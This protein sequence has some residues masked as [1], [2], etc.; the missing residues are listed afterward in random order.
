MLVVGLRLGATSG[1]EPSQF[2]ELQELR[3]AVG[4]ITTKEQDV[5]RHA[6]LIGALP[7]HT[8]RPLRRGDPRK[9]AADRY[10]SFGFALDLADSERHI[11]VATHFRNIHSDNAF[12]SHLLKN[13]GLEEI[14]TDALH[15]GDVVIYFHNADPA[16]AG[17]VFGDRVISK[18]GLGNLWE[19]A[20]FEIPVSYGTDVR[21]FRALGAGPA[22]AAFLKYAQSRGVQLHR[23][24]GFTTVSSAKSVNSVKA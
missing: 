19:H 3:K 6:A 1:Q 18:W 2:M 7:D 24:P 14:Q 16:H 12:V 5:S 13:G 22:E 11:A 4:D 10:N 20:L 8:I 17:K 15:K 21:Y 9:P 23:V